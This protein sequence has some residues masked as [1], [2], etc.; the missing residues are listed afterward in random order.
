MS[1]E[2]IDT[3]GGKERGR[4]IGKERGGEKKKVSCRILFP[5]YFYMS[6][7]GIERASERW[8]REREKEKK[9]KGEYI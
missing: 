3:D 9:K 1:I 4:V 8:E 7:A 6:I 5:K 2:G